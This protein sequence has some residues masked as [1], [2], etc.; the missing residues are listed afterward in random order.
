[1]SQNHFQHLVYAFITVF[2]TVH[3]FVFYSLYVIEGESLM[4]A[5]HTNSVLQAINGQVGYMLVV[6]IFANAARRVSAH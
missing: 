4:Q 5:S 2:I 6:Q 3:A 1:M